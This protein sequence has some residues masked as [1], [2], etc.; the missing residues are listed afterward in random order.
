MTSVAVWR[1]QGGTAAMT[2]AYRDGCGMVKDL[3]DRSLLHEEA[4]SA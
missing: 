1:R 4:V 3:V 2:R